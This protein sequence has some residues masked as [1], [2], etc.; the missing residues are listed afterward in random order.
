[1]FVVAGVFS[2]VLSDVLLVLSPRVGMPWHVKTA[3]DFASRVVLY[4]LQ[5]GVSASQAFLLVLVFLNAIDRPELTSSQQFFNGMTQCIGYPLTLYYVAMTL[6]AATILLTKLW[7]GSDAGLQNIST[8]LLQRHGISID[9][10]QGNPDSM[11]AFVKMFFGVWTMD[12]MLAFEI[13]QRAQNF[14]LDEE[15]VMLATVNQLS[16]PL[17]VIP[18]GGVVA[19]LGEYLNQSPIYV[20]GRESRENFSCTS[21]LIW[22]TYL[23]EYALVLLF[24]HQL[25]AE[26]EQGLVAPE[27]GGKDRTEL[28]GGLLALQVLRQAIC[29]LVRCQKAGGPFALG[30]GVQRESS[31][32]LS[33]DQEVGEKQPF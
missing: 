24:S 6:L 8:A 23:V 11:C 1:M 2:I 3:I 12:V 18:F 22:L 5:V 4:T 25:L 9:T 13:K 28:F 32:E 26:V 19:K 27:E 21:C 7:S 17:Y 29:S 14:R 20:A 15:E 33:S 30:A 10:V 16:F 31:S